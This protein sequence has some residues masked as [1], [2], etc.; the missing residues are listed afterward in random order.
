M[1][2]NSII[3]KNSKIFFDEYLI[4][5]ILFILVYFLVSSIIFYTNFRLHNEIVVLIITFLINIFF[6]KSFKLKT[7]GFINLRTLLIIVVVRVL[8]T[9]NPFPSVGGAQDQGLYVNMH[10]AYEK[11][12]F[13]NFRDKNFDFLIEEDLGDYYKIRQSDPGSYLWRKDEIL[14]KNLEKDNKYVQKSDF[15]LH[16]YTDFQFLPFTSLIFKTFIFILE[17]RTGSMV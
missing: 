7:I 12:V 14:N 6:Y 11:G 8:C 17:R 3:S 15:E 16:G 13:Q 2:L 9:L 5:F 10:K 1:I 4:R